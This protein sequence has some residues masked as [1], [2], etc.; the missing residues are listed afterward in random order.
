MRGFFLQLSYQVTS[1]QL[2]QLACWSALFYYI[3]LY[4]AW[5]RAIGKA[6]W[7]GGRKSD[8]VVYNNIII[9]FGVSVVLVQTSILPPPPVV[10]KGNSNALW[11]ISLLLSLV[12]SY[13]ALWIA[14]YVPSVSF[15]YAAKERRRKTWSGYLLTSFIYFSLIVFG[16][17]FIVVCEF[18]FSLLAWS[19]LCVH[20]AH[21]SMGE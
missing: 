13:T 15:N 10:K 6:C 21:A 11:H 12:L 4:H 20:H 5:T 7:Y 16:W 8:W 18:L 9:L 3:T 2:D 1:T 14:K 19:L 17:N